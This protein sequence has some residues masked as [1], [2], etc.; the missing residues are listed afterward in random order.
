MID[1]KDNVRLVGEVSETGTGTFTISVKE[2]FVDGVWLKFKE[3]KE[4]EVTTEDYTEELT[5]LELAYIKEKAK[6]DATLSTLCTDDMEV[7]KSIARK[8]EGNGA[9]R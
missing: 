1:V 2:F 3:A 9:D 7:V 8:L 4:I 6:K 5:S